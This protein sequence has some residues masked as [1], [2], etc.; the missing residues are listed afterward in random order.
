MRRTL[1]NLLL[2][3]GIVGF[4]SACLHGVSEA[5]LQRS[6]NTPQMGASSYWSSPITNT[7]ALKQHPL[8]M[9]TVAS[10]IQ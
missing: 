3:I 2:T 1:E 9:E 10:S 5:K 4:C 7:V 8:A 6:M